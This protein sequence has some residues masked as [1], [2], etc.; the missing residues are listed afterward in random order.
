MVDQ[1]RDQ[2]APA[3]SRT[4]QLVIASWLR[5]GQTKDQHQPHYTGLLHRGVEVLEASG[6]RPALGA[7]SYLNDHLADWL[8]HVLTGQTMTTATTAVIDYELERHTALQGVN[9][10][11][12]A[13]LQRI[14][15]ALTAVGARWQ[16]TAEVMA[17]AHPG[18]VLALFH[19]YG[20]TINPTVPQGLAM[21]AQLGGQPADH[22]AS[23][24]TSR[25]SCTAR[26]RSSSGHFF[27]SATETP[28]TVLRP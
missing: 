5:A 17:A 1:I 20:T 26:S 4:A 6:L 18:T 3:G 11:D 2:L 27:G 14:A 24:R 19:R 15:D 22:R 7:R 12:Q 21:H 9:E 13:H 28:F 10:P 8:D 23:G 16:D 25:Y